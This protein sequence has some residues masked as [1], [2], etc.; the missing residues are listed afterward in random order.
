M[1][2]RRQQ[3][4]PAPQPDEERNAPPAEKSEET[5][6]RGPRQPREYPDLVD[7]ALDDTFPASDPPSWSGR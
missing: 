2:R 6:R 7:E 4:Q 5:P 3:D 1:D